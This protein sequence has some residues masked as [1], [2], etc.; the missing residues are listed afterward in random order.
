VGEHDIACCAESIFEKIFSQRQSHQSGANVS[1]MFPGIFQAIVFAGLIAAPQTQT[2]T[3]IASVTISVSD[4]SGAFISGAE[5]A[6]R[7][8]PEGSSEER[9]TDNRGKVAADLERG[10]YEM[11]VTSPG[12]NTKRIDVEVQTSKPQTIA[13]KL[14]VSGTCSPCLVVGSDQTSLQLQSLNVQSEIE[15]QA[16]SPQRAPVALTTARRKMKTQ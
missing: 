3:Q 6:L 4:F 16:P 9:T 5:I 8:L 12:F 15:L 2:S 10:A 7:R 13:V 1:M 11:V 14:E